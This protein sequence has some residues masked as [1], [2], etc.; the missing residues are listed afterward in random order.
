MY[1]FRD[2]SILDEPI[3]SVRLDF[4]TGRFPKYSNLTML[5]KKIAFTKPVF[6]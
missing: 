6:A 2:S 4:I 3:F 1:G 5:C